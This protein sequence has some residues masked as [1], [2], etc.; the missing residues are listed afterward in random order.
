MRTT[1]ESKNAYNSTPTTSP[2]HNSATVQPSA[3][4]STSTT[5]NHIDILS[6]D[7]HNLNSD[8]SPVRREQRVIR[9]TS[10]QEKPCLQSQL[11]SRQYL[12]NL[13]CNVVGRSDA[14]VRTF[15]ESEEIVTVTIKGPAHVIHQL[16]VAIT[17]QSPGKYDVLVEPITVCTTF[18]RA[19]QSESGAALPALLGNPCT[20]PRLR[21]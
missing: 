11:C 4:S 7:L 19:L 12:L 16:V 14:D 18:Q 20:A 13:A 15:R 6:C 17:K 2:I 21:P 1:I 9:L 10:I 8:L 3:P 5:L